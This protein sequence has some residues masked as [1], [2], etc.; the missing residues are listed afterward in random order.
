MRIGANARCTPILGA[1]LDNG[2]LQPPAEA[3]CIT[4]LIQE[5]T[6]EFRTVDNSSL[7]AYYFPTSQTRLYKDIQREVV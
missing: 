4:G 1:G 5:G 2:L 6:W 7:S 3:L